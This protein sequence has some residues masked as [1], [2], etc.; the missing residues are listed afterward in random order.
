MAVIATTPANEIDQGE[1]QWA[2]EVKMTT[3]ERLACGERILRSIDA[4]RKST[5]D[6][7][8]LLPLEQAI[9]DRELSELDV[10]P[11]ASEKTFF[12]PNPRRNK[13]P[14]AR[15]RPPDA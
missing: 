4:R 13:R 8:D 2:S 3:K 11:M 9:V 15:W 7:D 6:P 5:K 1:M 14:S 12:K 10:A